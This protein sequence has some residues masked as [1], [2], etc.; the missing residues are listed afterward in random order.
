MKATTNRP[1]SPMLSI[2]DVADITGVATRTV[3]RWIKGG[4]LVVHRFG[5]AV[6]VAEADLKVFLALHRED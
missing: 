1:I 5:R 4:K 6:R 3:S 2:N